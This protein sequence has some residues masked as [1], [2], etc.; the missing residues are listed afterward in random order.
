[1]PDAM[2]DRPRMSIVLATDH[3][4]TIRRVVDHLRGQTVRDQLELVIVG[5][6]RQSLALDQ[7]GLEGFAGVRVVEVGADLQFPAARAAGVRAAAAPVVFIGETHSYPHTGW[8]EALIAAH[9]QPWAVVTPGFANANPDGALSWSIFLLDYGRWLAGLPAGEI[10]ISPTHNV[11]YKRAVLLELGDALEGALSHTDALTI[12]LASGGHRAYFEPHALIDHLNVSQPLAWVSERFL[13][14]LLIA[15]QRAQR[16]S[17][18][19]RL[20]YVCGS[21]LI[22]VVVLTRLMAGVRLAR[23]TARLPWGTLPGLVAAAVVAAAGEMVGYACGVG[24]AANQRMTEYELHK[25][26]YISSTKRLGLQPDAEPV[27]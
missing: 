21:P 27:Q 3:Y 14:G 6:T 9:D 12:H 10:A 13:C 25:R 24:H 4:E 7:A 5:P 18:L 22:P 26:R 16:W 23:R 17:F 15:G 8:A 2:P 19:R 20:A 1:M 11:A